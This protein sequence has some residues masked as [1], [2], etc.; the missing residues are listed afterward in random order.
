MNCEAVPEGVIGPTDEL[1]MERLMRKRTRS[2]KKSG[3]ATGRPGERLNRGISSEEDARHNPRGPFAYEWWYFDA[4]FSNGYSAVAVI[5][6]KDYARSWRRLCNV[7]LSIYGPGGENVT[8]YVSLSEREFYASSTRCDVRVGESFA[9]GAHSR[10]HLC[11][12]AGG[13]KVDLVFEAQTPGWKPGTG[14]NY[15]P[16]P[17]YGSMGWLVP[18]PRATVSGTLRVGDREMEVEGQGYHDHNWGEAPIFHF[19]DNWH[20]GHLVCGDIGIIWS[21]ITMNRS[22]GYDRTFMFLLSREGRLV[23]ESAD[24]SVLY[25]DWVDDPRYLHPYPGRITVSFGRKG[26]AARG[27]FTMRVKDVIETHDL[28]E[29]LGLPHPARRLVHAVY[30]KPYYFRW[31]SEVE[32]SV[33]VEGEKTSLG[34]VTIHEQ[35]IF[36]GRYP[37][38]RDNP[39]ACRS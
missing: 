16:F 15:L 2:V 1:S 25:R 10:Y 35:Q 30:S 36:R 20:W 21:D 13:E 24:I 38:E 19:V 26:E 7:Q 6:P 4:T 32:G 17:R 29:M 14:V 11:I 12:E 5:C 8:R 28:L 39:I 31:R 34:G 37:G 23:H 22:L 18:V 9:R 3:V 33:E 27:E